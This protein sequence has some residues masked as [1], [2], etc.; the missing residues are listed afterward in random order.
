MVS[1][2]TMGKFCHTVVGAATLVLVACAPSPPRPAVALVVRGDGATRARESVT[3]RD[4]GVDFRNV[5]APRGGGKA[6]ATEPSASAIEQRLVEAR[7]DYMDGELVRVRRCAEQL[8]APELVWSSLGRG[9]RPAAARVLIWKIACTSIARRDEAAVTARTFAGLELD[10]PADV[11]AI[12]VEAH[13]AL[14]AA[15]ESAEKSGKRELVIRAEG[16]GGVVTGARVTI[17]GRVAPCA[18]E[19]VVEL[20]PGDHL[21]QIEKDGWTTLEKVVRVDAGATR[22]TFTGKLALATP[23]LAAQQWG[24]RYATSDARSD[25]NESIT[26]LA[27]ALRAQRFVYL[28]TDRVGQGAR[29]RGA[30][31]IQGKIA[32][33]EEKQGSLSGT[34]ADV[35]EQLLVRGGIVEEKSL[36]KKPLF[37]VAVGVVALASSALTAYAIYDPGE[38]TIVRTK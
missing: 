28:E 2:N 4:L 5:E 16:E 31:A 19:C 25:S 35:V 24:A 34:S 10:L 36:L 18:T 29:I 9:A 27:Q 15:L 33:R 22:N 38:R 6:A 1:A 12:P 20:R 32:A 3:A 17:D 14:A 11:D 26:L 7:A 30:L 21:V 37:W 8:D 23:E 13:R